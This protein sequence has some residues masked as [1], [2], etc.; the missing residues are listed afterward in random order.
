MQPDKRRVFV[1]NCEQTMEIDAKALGKAVGD[2]GLTV[3]SH[4]CRAEINSY[5]KALSTG[6]PLLVCCTQEAPLFRELAEEAGLDALPAFTNIRERAGWTNDKQDTT[7]KMAA[8]IAEAGVKITPARAITL[9]SDG[10]CLVYGQG[11]AAFDIARKL[12]GRL[13]VTLLL[14]DAEGVI[15]PSVVDVPIFKG[16]IR[17]A[18]GHLGAFEIVVD[19]Y[20]PAIPSARRSL[21]FIMPRDGA[22]STCSLIIDVSGNDPLFSQKD[23]LDGYF[24]VDAASPAAVSECVFAASDLIGEFEKPI[25]VNYDADICAHARNQKTGCTKCLDACPVSAITPDSDHVRID[26]AVCGGC[27]ACA[28]VCPTGASSYALPG[29]EDV[30]TRLQTLITAYRAAGG[31][32]PVLLVHDERHGGEMINMMARF[33][34]GLPANVLPFAVNEVTQIGHDTL[35]AALAIGA[36][37]ILLLIDPARRDE[38]TGLVEEA[39]LTTA[40]LSA[41]GY[42][43]AADRI[44]VVDERDP[45]SLEA[46]LWDVSAPLPLTPHAFI[47]A[48]GKRQAARSAFFLLNADAP[49]P[50]DVIA[51]PPRAP[52]GRID[53]RT[54]GCTLCLACVSTC[55]MGAIR[56]NPERPQIRFIEQDCVQCGLCASTCPEGV[57]TLEPRLNLTKDAMTPVTL[58]EEEPAECIRCGKPFGTKSSIERIIAQLAGKH[59]MFQ[60]EDAQ[61]LIRMC[62]T[63]RIVAQADTMTDPFAMGERP[64]VR[65]T[66]DDLDERDLE[67]KKPS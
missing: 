58:H 65:T 55:P 18:T 5:T 53:V 10:V 24:H 26:P 52:Y 20:A 63:C 38:T 3:H 33:G 31:A 16:N 42:A 37:R 1:C 11:E 41:L 57:I 49:I 67:K 4:L 12:A 25:Y 59:S 34:R 8:L 17:A 15:P 28:S 50:Q 62:D 9:K 47:A 64:R 66:Q 44:T 7:A 61:A 32:S 27:G 43:G 40:V 51:L 29:R 60:S 14:T 48:S 21:D 19:G 36:E 22:S 2:P 39:G 6:D 23:R 54:D 13:S 56:D 46:Q 45:D 30:Q 35:A